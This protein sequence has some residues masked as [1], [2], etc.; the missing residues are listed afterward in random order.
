LA[1]DDYD[2]LVSTL[3]RD[4]FCPSASERDAFHRSALERDAS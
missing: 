1:H 2:S 4:V 3:E